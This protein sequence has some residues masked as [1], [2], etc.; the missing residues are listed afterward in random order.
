[1]SYLLPVYARSSFTFEKGEGVYLYDKVGKKYLDFAAGIAVNSMGHCHPHLVQALEEQ[2]KKLWHTSNMYHIDQAEEL[3]ERIAKASKFADYVFFCNSGGEAVECGIKMVRKYHDETGNPDKYRIITFEGAFHGRTMATISAANKGKL[4]EGFFPLLDGFDK[5]PFDDLEAVKAA[6]TPE[7]GGILIEP[8]Q[9]EGGI[10]PCSK[11]FLQGLRKICDENGLLLFFDSV[12]CGMGR[13]GKFFSHEWAGVKPDIVSSA[14]GIGGGFPMGACLCTKEVGDT[15]TPG[16]H[17]STYAGNP[18]AIAVCSAV[19]DIMLADG[20]L[21]GV[22]ETGEYLQAE[23][24]KLKDE[25]PSVIS[26]IRGVGLMIGIR[27]NDD[28]VKDNRKFVN[29]LREEGFLSAPAAENVMRLLPPLIITKE[30]CDEAVA[31]IRSYIAKNY[32]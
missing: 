12:Q 20:F 18:L 21:D 14:K 7:T 17:G 27:L 19:M 10:R 25:Y 15:M 11:E 4:T 3:A 5:V 2:N 23:L 26:E 9:G 16:S 8:V 32:G 28:V 29:D 30:H 1:M 31:I 22:V 6:I 13:T 24:N